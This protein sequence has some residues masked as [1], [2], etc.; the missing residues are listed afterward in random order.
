M[1]Y[2]SLRHIWRTVY[3]VI[4]GYVTPM[5]NPQGRS[6]YIRQQQLIIYALLAL[7]AGGMVFVATAQ[8][9]IGYSPDSFAY[10]RG[11][12]LLFSDFWTPSEDL[13]K[14]PPLFAFILALLGQNLDLITLFHAGVLALNIGLIAFTLHLLD[15]RP[16][17]AFPVLIALIVAPELVFRHAMVMSEPVFLLLIQLT[18]LCSVTGRF[19]WAVLFAA[20]APMQ[21]YAGVALIAACVLYLLA[22]QRNWRQAVLFGGI[23]ALPFIGWSI[24]GSIVGESPRQLAWHPITISHI[25]NGFFTLAGRYGFAPVGVVIVML[26]FL[27]RGKLRT[28]SIPPLIWLYGIFI[29]TYIGFL[30]VSISLLD[31]FTPLDSRILSPVLITGWMIIAWLADTLLRTVNY[32]R[33]SR[34]MGVLFNLAIL[35]FV[36]F[37]TARLAQN[38]QY[39]T[40]LYRETP[41]E[42]AD[43]LAAL[44]QDRLIYANNRVIIDVLA[45]NDERLTDLQVATLPQQYDPITLID[46]PDYATEYTQLADA[47]TTGNALVVYFDGFAPPGATSRAEL[48][49]IGVSAWNYHTLTVFGVA[50]LT[51]GLPQ[52]TPQ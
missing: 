27:E 50:D 39:G 34:I 9:G 21:R 38:S 36:L 37:G 1:V 10:L 48:D 20:L 40:G 43:I 22:V 45:L 13:T 6:A 5:D 41:P 2:L 8:R 19:W 51:Q 16:V 11:A 31:A 35:S 4:L 46:N 42:Y 29:V 52:P 44:P 25:R 18:L 17:V 30:V 3:V 7:F 24:R 28:I 33:I 26:A 12:D 47:L 14:F 23:T 49:A 32:R 15:I